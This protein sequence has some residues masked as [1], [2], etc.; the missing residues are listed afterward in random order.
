MKYLK[1]TKKKPKRKKGRKID[2]ELARVYKMWGPVDDIK[3][4]FFVWKGKYSISPK[5]DEIY[6]ILTERGLRFYREI[7][8]DT[9][10]RFDFYIPLI[11]LVIE[12]D[13]W[14]HFSML[15]RMETDITKEKTLKRLGV[16][17]IRYN[18]THELEKQIKHDLVYHPVLVNTLSGI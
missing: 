3:R 6:R 15:D 10:K 4:S 8:F 17:L 16:K 11:D 5:E 12:Y 18:K 9:I 2:K 1:N 7:S 14:R 13:G